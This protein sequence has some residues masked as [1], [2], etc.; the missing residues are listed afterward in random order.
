[1]TTQTW[2][3]IGTPPEAL[4]RGP[5]RLDRWRAEDVYDLFA[6]V[7]SSREH[8]APFMPWSHAY[9]RGGAETYLAVSHRNWADRT[10]F[11][12]RVSAAEVSPD[13]VLGSVGLMARRGPGVL[14]IGYWI[15]ASA[16]RRGLA[17]RAS[18]ALTDAAL[19]LP[20]VTEIWICHVPV[21][22]ASAAIPARL[23]FTR[24]VASVPGP[25]GYEHERDVCWTLSKE[26]WASV[27]G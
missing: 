5:V 14:E 2:T 13:R 19:A 17:W 24:Q 1:M 25:P 9:E 10:A 8:L 21:N 6:A 18:A 15:R 23:G 12:Y 22:E 3:P 16:V 27:R 11:N 26:A 20:G 4:D 7:D